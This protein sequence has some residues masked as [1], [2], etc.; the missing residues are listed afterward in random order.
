MAGA[1]MLPGFHEGYGTILL[2]PPW[3][4]HGGGKSKRGCRRHYPTLPTA[5]M[6]AVIRGSGKF[7]PSERGCHLWMWVTDNFLTDGLWLIDQLGFRYVRTFQW[8]KLK[9]VT[10][11]PCTTDDAERGYVEA[12]ALEAA[13]NALQYG[14][15]QYGRGAHEMILLSVRGPTRLPGTANRQP[16][17]FFAT[18]TQHSRKPDEAF[19]LIHYTSPG[20]RIEFFA[21]AA[22]DG[23]DAWGN[24]V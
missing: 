24:E 10:I 7:L 11:I 19:E 3:Q 14:L 23:W 5:E 16:S 4:E 2:D 15:G 18:R 17:V 6:P 22:R 1:L 9:A 20:P 21:R 12:N 8:I 13:R